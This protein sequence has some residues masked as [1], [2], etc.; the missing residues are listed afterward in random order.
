MVF[1]PVDVRMIKRREP[2]TSVGQAGGGDR[3]IFQRQLVQHGRCQFR[4]RGR[5]QP[6]GHEA[7]PTTGPS[8]GHQRPG[9]PLTQ[10]PQQPPPGGPAWAPTRRQLHSLAVGPSGRPHESGRSHHRRSPGTGVPGGH[11]PWRACVGHPPPIPVEGS[12]WWTQLPR[13]MHYGI[14]R[15]S[16]GCTWTPSPLE[17]CRGGGEAHTTLAPLGRRPGVCHHVLPGWRQG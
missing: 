7:W 5:C 12:R 11:E 9:W 16:P 17:V 10:G 3:Q 2:M 15:G 13:R 4:V 1:R 14:R 8:V 6:Q